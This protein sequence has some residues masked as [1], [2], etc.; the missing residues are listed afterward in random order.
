MPVK[1]SSKSSPRGA[2]AV[3]KSESHDCCFSKDC[4]TKVRRRYL[5][6]DFA[7]KILL[8]LAGILLAYVIV[9]VGTMIRNN[10]QKFYSIGQ[11]ERPT[12]YLT[13]EA[14][15]KVVA[16]PDVAM[17]SMGMNSEAS[18]VEEAQQKNTD[19]M[20][21]LIARVKD[22]GVDEADIQTANYNVYPRT[23]SQCGWWAPVCSR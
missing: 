1:A 16:R 9:L 13:V 10:L 19:T 8:T 18:T 22:L 15:G 11:A 7:Q 2:V 5:S 3:S 12:N 4:S 21:K 14:D 20:N 17:V 6:N 23:R